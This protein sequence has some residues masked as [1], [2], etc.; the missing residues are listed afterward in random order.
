MIRALLITAGMSVLLPFGTALADDASI[1]GA[2]VSWTG[3]Y[4]GGHV[5]YGQ[6]DT[7]WKTKAVART[8]ICAQVAR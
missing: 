3:L 1:P 4:V 6:S 5:G 7:H 2:T 8:P